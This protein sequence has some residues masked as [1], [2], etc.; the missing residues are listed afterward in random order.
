MAKKRFY[1]VAVGREPGIYTAWQ[2]PGGAQGQVDGYQG[3]RY[4][5]FP[6]RAEAEAWLREARGGASGQATSTPV[7]RE[8][9]D[10]VAADAVLA[11]A[12]SEGVRIYTD[13]GA[14]GNPG[15]GGYGVVLVEGHRRTELS[16]GF[17]LT[18]NNRMELLACIVGL[19]AYEG[20]GPVRVF[21][22]SR[23]VIR[24]MTEGW[25]ARWR[26]HGWWRNKREKA[27][28]IDLWEHLLELAEARPVEFVW[29][30]GHSG[31]P[32]NEVCDRLATA[33]SRKPNLPPDVGYEEAQA[34]SPEQLSFV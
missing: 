8:R 17:R 1:A 31:H 4:R 2:G 13:G 34:G 15:P 25:A 30:R 23:Y 27:E 28:N 20:R 26:A 11:Q 19:R 33:A 9:A 5:G 6:T 24:A 29:V 18:T 22:D 12:G 32:M 7:A 10:T 21:S 16:G 3:A 14:I